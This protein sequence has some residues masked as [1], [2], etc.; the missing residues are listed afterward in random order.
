MLRFAVEVTEEKAT[1]K[2]VLGEKEYV[3]EWVKDGDGYSTTGTP[4]SRQLEDDYGDVAVYEEDRLE[5]IANIIG[6]LDGLSFIDTQA[7]FETMH[8]SGVPIARRRR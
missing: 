6:D 5:P 3:E 4:I 1:M 2:L 7:S 8:E